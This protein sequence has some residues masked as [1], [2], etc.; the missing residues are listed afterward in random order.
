MRQELVKDWMTE[1]VVTVTPEM[2]L[3]DAENLMITHMIRR[4]PVIENGRLVGIVT[5]GDIRS[6]RPSRA[7]SLTMWES[8]FL[9]ARLKVSEFMTAD[10]VTIPV[11]ATIG[12]AAQLMLKYMVS[13]LPVVDDQDKLIGIITESDIF[14]LVATEWVQETGEISPA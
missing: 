4:L 6:V 2:T 12:N 11:D 13:G 3:P 10:P 9:A 8:N 1:G 14:R 7:A 5:Y